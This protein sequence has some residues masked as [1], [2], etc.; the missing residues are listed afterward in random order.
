MLFDQHA[1][2]EAAKAFRSTLSAQQKQQLHEYL[3]RMFVD[4]TVREHPHQVGFRIAIN[5][6][7]THLLHERTDHG[8]PG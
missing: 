1:A 8:I 7:E 4:V 6:I 3:Q 5:E 2:A